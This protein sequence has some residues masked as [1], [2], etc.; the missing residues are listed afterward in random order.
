MKRIGFLYSKIYNKENIRL[1]IKNAQKGKLFYQEVKDINKNTEKYVDILHDM[2][3]NKTY[4]TSEYEVF[5]KNDKGK[6]REIYKLPFFPDRVCH[7]TII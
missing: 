2:L 4:K 1:A 3:K 5:I 6:E 7:W